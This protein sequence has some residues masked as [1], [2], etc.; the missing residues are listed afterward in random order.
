MVLTDHGKP[1]TDGPFDSKFF[2]VVNQ[3]RR[4][5]LSCVLQNVNFHF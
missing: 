4:S 2:V 3:M 5:Q 1:L